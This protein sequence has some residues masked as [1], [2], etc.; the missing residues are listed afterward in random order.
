[1]IYVGVDNNMYMTTE[2]E[3]NFYVTLHTV[4]CQLYE[5]HNFHIFADESSTVKISPHENVGIIDD[6]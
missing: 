6:V 1:M 5:V 4:Q 2:L 3:H